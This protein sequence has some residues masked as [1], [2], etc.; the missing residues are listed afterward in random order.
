MATSL[1]RTNDLLN[2]LS[3]F[4]TIRIITKLLEMPLVRAKLLMAPLLLMKQLLQQ[5]LSCTMR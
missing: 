3:R 4:F 2:I 5:I 1:G